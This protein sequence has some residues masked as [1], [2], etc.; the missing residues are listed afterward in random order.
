MTIDAACAIRTTIEADGGRGCPRAG[1]VAFLRDLVARSL[2]G[3]RL[4][5]SDA[6]AG[7]AHT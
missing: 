4:V 5:T 7:S 6:H 1:W 2:A 3:V